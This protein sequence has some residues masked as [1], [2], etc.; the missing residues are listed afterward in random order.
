MAVNMAHSIDSHSAEVA[1]NK[2]YI[3]VAPGKKLTIHFVAKYPG[4]F[5]YYCATQPVLMHTSAGMRA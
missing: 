5:M 2:N 1:P 4:V 3:D